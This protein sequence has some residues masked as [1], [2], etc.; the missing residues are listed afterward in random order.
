MHRMLAVCLTVA[1]LFGFI[2]SGQ[3]LSQTVE[4]AAAP[5]YWGAYVHNGVDNTALIDDFESRAGKRVS[6]FMFGQSWKRNGAYQPFPGMYLQRIRDRGTIP[7]LDWFSAELGMGVNQPNFQLRDI[8]NGNHDA[9]ITTWARGSR[10]WGKPYFLRMNAEMNG[11]W[12][13]FS[14]QTNGNSSG[15]FVKAWRHVVDIF[16]REGANNVTWIWCP[17]VQGPSSTALPGLYPG[18]TYVDWVC[19]D[20][21]NYGTDH[22]NKWHPF[23][24]I[25]KASNYNGWIDTYALLGQVAP[26]K[27]IMIGETASSEDGGSKA[28]WITML[29]GTELP[30]GFPRVKALIW[31][32]WDVDDPVKDWPIES[33]PASQ[34]A[35]RAGIASSYYTSNQYGSITASPI[36][37]PTGSVQTPPPHPPTPTPAP[38]TPTSS[39][40]QSSYRD[41]VLADQPIA[42]WRL[43]ET[44]GT[45]A[46]DQRGQRP[47]S[48]AGAPTL[49]ATGASPRDTDRATTFNGVNEY[50]SVPDA[51]SFTP[52]VGT[53][54]KLSLEAWVKVNALP[55]AGPGTIVSKA[56]AGAYE[57][58]LRVHPNGSVEMVLWAP[59]G[60]TYQAAATP[61]GAVAAGQWVH[62]VATCENRVA[63]RVYVNGVQRGSAT[64]G[65]GT[66]GPANGTAPLNI[67]RRADGTQYLN[68]TIDE[69]AIYSG[70]LSPTRVQAHYNAGR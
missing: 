27:P 35:F 65:W 24:N 19:M 29:L 33:S 49:G 50:V 63:C 12:H 20:G 10:D 69:V 54:G 42:Y 41:T 37:P 40:I 13:P 32:N 21:Y 8:Y 36:Q 68:A 23:T 28:T 43:G 44:S 30:V 22:G 31:F 51:G 4:A 53:A 64:G 55:G 48:Y 59:N 39:P 67:G 1:L 16:R 70:A 15:D 46:A 52:L 11:W 62:L 6:L 66:T 2:W 5:I 9:Y 25:F 17:N 7:V 56:A 18:D 45:V 38:A 60:D 3:P 34:A 26:T 47:G 14:E 57:H 61:A 58:S